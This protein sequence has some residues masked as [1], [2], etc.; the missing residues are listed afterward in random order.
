MKRY[1]IQE[2]ETRLETDTTGLP[3]LGSLGED[4]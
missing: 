4:A 3:C 2:Q 1:S